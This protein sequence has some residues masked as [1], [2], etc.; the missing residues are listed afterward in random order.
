MIRKRVL[1]IFDSASGTLSGD[2][3]ASGD[4]DVGLMLAQKVAYTLRRV[5]RHNGAAVL[6]TQGT[7]SGDGSGVVKAAMVKLGM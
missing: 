4:G 1:V 6:V 7:V 5:A 2:L 3:Y